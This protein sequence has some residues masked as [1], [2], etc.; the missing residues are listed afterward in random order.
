MDIAFL[1]DGF[2][3]FESRAYLNAGTCGP[4]PAAAL[5]AAA[6]VAL[7]AAEAGRTGEH[8]ELLAGLRERLRT[9]YAALL[10]ADAR[11]VAM[12]SCASEGMARVIGGLGL[13]PG[14]E[15]LTAPDE[16]PGLLGPLAA[17]RRLRGIEVRTAPLGDIADAVG[18]R[19]RLVACSH[20]SW[21][22]GEPAPAALARLGDEVPVLLDGA[23]GV[24]AIPVDVA[25]LGCA[26]YAGAGQ[27]W[28]C[29]PVGT[30]MLYAAPVWRERLAP[31]GPTYVNL[32]D[33]GAG[34]DAAP[35]DDARRHDAW[36]IGAEVYAAAL[37]AHDTLA[38]VGWPAVHDRA[39]ALAA[40]FAAA[41]AE[42]GLT[43][44]PRG[45]TTLVAWEADD[46]PELVQ[47]LADAG[48]VVRHLPGTRYVRA[49]VGAWNDESD[50]DRLLA[51]L[52]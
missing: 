48:V 1:R 39:R 5:R 22:T 25:E 18:P 10:G 44:A 47:R 9:A 16:H 38:S 36:A 45:E 26:F 49:S 34:L 11:D 31:L 17:A 15:V 27:K 20:V 52:P 7:Q 4:V 23:Q 19:T 46:P 40:A 33:P 8:F 50:L 2:P 3:V 43:V 35:H 30:G 12:T 13:A 28:L 6:D 51:A 32:A 14:D 42:R 29:G 41:L 24:G 37:A 21:V